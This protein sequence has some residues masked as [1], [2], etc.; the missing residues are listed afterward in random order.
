LLQIEATYKAW[1]INT[2]ECLNTKFKEDHFVN[3]VKS[4]EKKRPSNNSTI[5]ITTKFIAELNQISESSDKER[6]VKQVGENKEG[7]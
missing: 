3:T 7:S 6:D 2:A 5:L 4:H 1:V